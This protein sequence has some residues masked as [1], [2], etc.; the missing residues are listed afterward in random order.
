MPPLPPADLQAPGWSVR[1]G[2][3]VWTSAKGKDDVA[4][5]ILL[6]TRARGE[7]FVQFAKPPFTL[8]TA[9]AEAGGWSVE[10]A[11]A[12]RQFC[13]RGP[14]PVRFVWFALAEAC[15]GRVV[16]GG[17]SFEARRGTGW[18]LTNALTG[19]MLEGYLTP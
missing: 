12:R 8:A 16:G 11:S 10:L 1:Q 18:C 3:A 15:C 13:G 14:G 2:Q 17:W 7:C 19:E 9:R 5:E 6:A 4:G